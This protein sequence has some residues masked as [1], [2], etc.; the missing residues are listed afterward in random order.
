M[1]EGSFHTF[2]NLLLQV[3]GDLSPEICADV[4]QWL[5]SRMLSSSRDKPLATMKVNSTFCYLGG[6]PG[7]PFPVFV[8]G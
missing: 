3:V 2:T 6:Y 1:E 4:N 8:L 7:S 5:L